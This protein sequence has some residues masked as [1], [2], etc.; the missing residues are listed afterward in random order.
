[1]P[2][3]A[4]LLKD[5]LSRAWSVLPRSGG[6][7]AAVLT[8][9]SV[10]PSGGTGFCVK[11]E[12]FEEHVR[13]LKDRCTPVPLSRVVAALDGEPLPDRAVAL[14][15]D[16]GYL[17]NMEYS[18]PLLERYGVPATI[19]L[20]TAYLDGQV[21]LIPG[22]LWRSMSWDDARRLKAGGLIDFGAHGDT[23]DPLGS[24]TPLEA[25]YEAAR[26]RARMREELGEA[27][28]FFAY[29][30]GQAWDIGPAA[31]ESCRSAGY[32]AAFS[33]LWG[34]RL[35]AAERWRLPRVR[36]DGEDGL[37]ALERKADGAYDFVRGVH[38]AKGALVEGLRRS[39][40]AYFGAGGILRGHRE[41]TEKPGDY[42][43]LEV[44][45]IISARYAFAAERV[46]GRRVLEVGCGAGMGLTLLA[47]RAA[48]LEGG[49]FDSENLRQARRL[50]P[51]G[52]PLQRLDAHALGGREGAFDAVVALAMIY[53]LDLGRFFAEARRVL[54]PGGRLIFCTSNKDV[55]GFVPAPGTTR[56]HSVPELATALRA[57]GF[58]SEFYGGF[59][60]SFSTAAR[61]LR[62]RLKDAAKAAVGVLPGGR[63][64][65]TLLRFATRGEKA[66]LPPLVEQMA[67]APPLVRLDP[68]IP[69][70]V[71]R[72]IYVCAEKGGL[73]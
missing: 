67:A 70:Q 52:V 30:N 63:T 59:P 12:D 21:E 36:V 51:P 15:F 10:H 17:D 60:A 44:Q 2:R 33:T 6:A 1:M 71:H 50:A 64:A 8:Y 61:G 57:A 29:P 27:P 58:S 19:F 3:A 5:V 72:V 28:D 7:R 53:Y 34:T 32:R 4:A 66:R 73:A 45:Q 20:P 37:R 26:A 25:R 18:A 55:A 69:D 56:Y 9:H 24:L 11:P 42:L 38:L 23:H 48:S 54:S 47:S 31:E 13:F 46:A 14:T 22:S 62:G 41:Q 65:W 40:P 39:A 35:R 16:D 49:D 43:P 68:R